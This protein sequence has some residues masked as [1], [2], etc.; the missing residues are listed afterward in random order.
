[1]KVVLFL[2]LPEYLP[3]PTINAGMPLGPSFGDPSF[4]PCLDGAEWHL[5]FW[6]R[7]KKDDQTPEAGVNLFQMADLPFQL[8][9]SRLRSTEVKSPARLPRP[10]HGIN[11]DS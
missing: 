9:D 4:G 7:S 10:E 1:M 2:L 5:H 3:L 8:P 11:R 6:A